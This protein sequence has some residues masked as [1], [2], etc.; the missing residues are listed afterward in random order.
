MT[1]QSSAPDPVFP[2]SG[3]WG[4]IWYARLAPLPGGRWRVRGFITDDHPDGAI[5]GP[6]VDDA[7]LPI[8]RSHW[9]AELDHKGRTVVTVSPWAVAGA[10]DLWYVR[11]PG[12]KEGRATFTLAA[13]DTDHLPAGT[14]VRNAEFLVL[15]VASDEQV[16][17][18]RWFTDDGLVDQ[19]YVAPERRGSH[20]A[21]MLLYA[22][23]AMHQHHGWAGSLH[24]GPRRTDLGENLAARHPERISARTE[25]GLMV[26]PQTGRPTA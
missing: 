2:E 5:I 11:V 19:V 25:I 24:G 8:D 10:P 26:D 12:E 23:A 20:V 14:V 16:G 4:S 15:P 1:P 22:A 6:A 7:T 21:R 3:P 17:A 13:Y 9:L 18:V